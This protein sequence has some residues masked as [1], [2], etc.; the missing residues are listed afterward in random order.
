MSRSTTRLCLKCDAVYCSECNEPMSLHRDGVKCAELRASKRQRMINDVASNVEDAEHHKACPNCLV[1]TQK[2]AGCNSMD[3]SACGS[4]WC[5][6]CG[7][8]LVKLSDGF[9]EKS[10]RSMIAHCHFHRDINFYG[11]GRSPEFYDKIKSSRNVG[12]MDKMHSEE[13]GAYVVPKK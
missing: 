7:R 13:K 8:V 2:D 1:V 12:C 10:V 6:L 4:F 3:C 5:W 9:E 11:K